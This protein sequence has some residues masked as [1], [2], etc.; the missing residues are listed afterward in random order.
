[1]SNIGCH[2]IFTKAQIVGAGTDTVRNLPEKDR[3]PFNA[4]LLGS[5]CIENHDDLNRRLKMLIEGTS[6]MSAAKSKIFARA[7]AEEIAN[8]MGITELG[9]FP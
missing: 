4:K 9:E 5:G 8:S 3:R 7:L 6:R 1:M 2:G